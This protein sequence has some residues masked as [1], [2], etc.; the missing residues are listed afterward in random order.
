MTWV[1]A[2][3]FMQ[4]YS[5][6]IADICVTFEDPKTKSKTYADCLLKIHDISRDN[7]LM[8]GFSGRVE[9]AFNIIDDMRILASDMALKSHNRKFDVLDFI[10]EWQK[11]TV[12]NG[13]HLY[14]DYDNSVHMFIAGNH[15]EVDSVGNRYAPSGVYQ[16]KSPDYRPMAT[17]PFHWS[18]IGSGSDMVVCKAIVDQLS[19]DFI[20]RIA[21][22][23]TSAEKLVDFLAP[24][25]S[26]VLEQGLTEK[27]VSSSLVIGISGIGDTALATTYPGDDS[28]PNKPPK[29]ATTYE[30]LLTM[31]DDA[32]AK[33]NFFASQRLK[34]D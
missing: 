30:E 14:D 27:G 15:T 4:D 26:A 16:V 20:F 18:H 29:L 12:N 6:I 2:K 7:G 33:A 11:Y 1:L 10:K 34:S 22:I 5:L 32:S 28:I 23:D 25:I 21:A 24:R 31:F 9:N 17:H 19:N 8:V 3:P 13:K